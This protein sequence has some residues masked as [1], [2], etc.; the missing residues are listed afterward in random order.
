MA[1]FGT[2]EVNHSGTFN[3][4]VMA[5][6]AVIATLDVLATD[7]PYERITAHGSALMAGLTALGGKHGLPLRVQ[8][9]PMSFHASFGPPEPLTDYRGLLTR[10]LPG[11]AEFAAILARYGVWVA[12]RGIWYVSAAHGETELSTTLER[13][14]RAMSDP[15]MAAMTT[16][17]PASTARTAVA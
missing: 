11:Y 13:V 17:A 1:R 12:G 16:A 14:D 5:A 8:G 9:L 6:A 3:G 7:P 4:S 2:G 10:D 15:A